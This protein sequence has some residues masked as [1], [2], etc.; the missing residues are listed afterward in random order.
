MTLL[1]HEVVAIT[2]AVDQGRRAHWGQREARPGSF[3]RSRQDLVGAVD[4]SG[5]TIRRPQSG[6]GSIEGR[7]HRA[8]VCDRFRLYVHAFGVTCDGIVF[9]LV[10]MNFDRGH[11]DLR[12]EDCLT[13]K[14]YAVHA[15]LASHRLANAARRL[16]LEQHTGSNDAP[17]KKRGASANSPLAAFP[18]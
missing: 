10:E 16:A 13:G 14:A 2:A 18:E 5:R 17:V 15:R 7:D 3:D 1:M 9:R 4:C 8:R 12:V 11:D 6:H